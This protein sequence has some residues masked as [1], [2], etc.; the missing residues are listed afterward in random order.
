MAEVKRF[1]IDAK[2]IPRASLIKLA[3]KRGVSHERV[4]EYQIDELI[5]PETI[6]GDINSL[7]V[8]DKI[9]YPENIEDN[10]DNE[11]TEK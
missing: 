3:L 11:K 6:T 1:Q 7:P 8:P 4:S 5:D 9:K 10:E 2:L